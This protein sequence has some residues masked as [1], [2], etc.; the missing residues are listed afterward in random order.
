MRVVL[1]LRAVIRALLPSTCFL[2]SS[3]VLV[4]M[5]KLAFGKAISLSH[6][7]RIEASKAKRSPYMK[8]EVRINL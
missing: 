6:S 2:P 1:L 5:A 4:R 3:H 8:K 7:A